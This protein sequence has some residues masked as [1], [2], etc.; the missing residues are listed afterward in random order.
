VKVFTE[1][2]DWTDA[3]KPGAAASAAPA[4]T[5]AAGIEAEVQKKLQE[6]LKGLPGL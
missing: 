3:P 5:D 1:G 6:A 4:P 2:L